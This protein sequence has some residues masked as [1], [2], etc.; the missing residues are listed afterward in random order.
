[1]NPTNLD[2]GEDHGLLKRIGRFQ[3]EGELGRGGMGIVLRARDMRLDRQVAIKAIPRGRLSDP[4]VGMRFEREARLAAAINHLNVAT[5]YGIEEQDGRTYLIFEY[6]AGETLAERL[7]RAP[8]SVREVLDLCAQVAAG[9]AAA[10]RCGVVHRDLK[11]ANVMITTDGIAKVLD[12]GLGKLIG[13]SERGG[14]N[15]ATESGL[16]LGTL[17]YMSPEQVRGGQVDERS[18]VW[19]LGCVLYEC[20]T[21]RRAFGG[22]TSADAIV[23]V[24]QREPDWTAI[25]PE[26]PDRIHRLLRTS[27][28]KDPCNRPIDANAFAAALPGEHAVRAALAAGETPTPEMVAAAG[29]RGHLTRRQATLWIVS[30]VAAIFGVVL[31]KGRVETVA[32][33]PL[34]KPP[35][36]LVE[37]ARTMVDQLGVSRT[38]YDT[39]ASW[40]WDE[41][42]WRWIQSEVPANARD[43]ALHTARPAPLVFWYRESPRS[44][45]ALGLDWGVVTLSDP[46]LD[47]PGML[48]VVLDPAGR[49]IELVRVPSALEVESDDE[50]NPSIWDTLFAEA[51]LE[52]ESFLS[53]APSGVPPTFCDQRAAWEGPFPSQ[54]ELALRVEAGAIGSRPV[55]FS[56][57]PRWPW[58]SSDSAVAPEVELEW[59]SFLHLAMQVLIALF[60]VALAWRQWRT[61][62]ADV[63]GARRF[64]LYALALGIV[65]RI[66]WADHTVDAKSEALLFQAQLGHAVFRA[67]ILWT[68]YLGVESYIR[69]RWPSRMV[70]WNRLMAGRVGDPMVG[71]DVLVGTTVGAVAQLITYSQFGLLHALEIPFA[72]YRNL[73]PALLNGEMR[74]VVA[75]ILDVQVTAIG[76]ILAFVGA[77]CLLV[78][79]MRSEWLARAAVLLLLFLIQGLPAELELTW[80]DAVRLSMVFVVWIALAERVGVLACVAGNCIFNLLSAQPHLGSAEAWWNA[81]A[82][83]LIG[84]EIVLVFLCAWLA[85][86]PGLENEGRAQGQSHRGGAAAKSETEAVERRF[87]ADDAGV[88]PDGGRWMAAGE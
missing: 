5:I 49:L 12:F 75:C 58:R 55:Y 30:A 35:A 85:A 78:R 15:V 48:R 17:G 25:P 28:A 53:V 63:R 59:R 87:R 69:R 47:L 36:V 42:A 74:S 22:S 32:R 72:G 14:Q 9:V 40:A 7:V 31:L 10:H 57:R 38:P 41:D 71:R 83:L 79:V 70:S 4:V 1:M 23:S 88:T 8:L 20:L 86:R 51:G 11:P 2:A 19:A 80:I 16:I 67:L 6:V 60:L 26:T 66:L 65:S 50:G 13:A 33:M 54:D 43:A 81:E 37:R 21:G 84:I 82:W 29:V 52:S 44:L 39:K 62:A 77:F 64:A 27:L 76:M 34:D 56:I 46:P 73:S 18:D 68:V 61:G 45:A 3:T 24:L